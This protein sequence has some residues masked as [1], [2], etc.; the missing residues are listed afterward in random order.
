M[1][2]RQK[3]WDAFW[4][5]CGVVGLGAL[6]FLALSWV[7]GTA[8]RLPSLYA[9]G[10]S[11]VALQVFSAAL[12]SALLVL[13]MLR[14]R[15]ERS[16]DALGD[17]IRAAERADPLLLDEGPF[18]RGLGRFL[19]ILTVVLALV[20]VTTAVLDA[21][22]YFRLIDED[23]I[24]E[25]SS[26]LSWF[27]ATAFALASIV[28]APPR[29]RPMF[30]VL[31]LLAVF[32]FVCGGEEISWGQRIL[33]RESGEFFGRINKQHETNL[34]NIGSISIFANLFFVG[35]LLFFPGRAWLERRTPGLRAWIAAQ[36]GPWL[37]VW[38]RR[39]YLVGL[40]AFVAVGLRFQ[41]LGFSPWTRK[42]WY[43]QMDDEIFEFFVAFAFCIFALLDLVWR[44][45]QRKSRSQEETS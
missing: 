25:Y 30:V 6:A 12:L 35:S 5:L 2:P 42:G 27:L 29:S 41:T 40:A 32:F 31:L 44:W 38:A 24:V 1:N 39:C 16:V 23:G 34:H 45:H 8:E 11:T 36:R 37:S 20:A 7:P 43:N 3:R 15:L 33:G 14:H 19:L 28:L 13:W 4:W 17:Q 22:A 21:H 10:M 26:A 18:G 9:R